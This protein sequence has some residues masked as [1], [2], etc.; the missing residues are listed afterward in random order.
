M[1]ELSHNLWF[2][3]PW[4]NPIFAF[5]INC[6]T[7]VASA[8]TFKRYHLEHHSFQGTDVWDADIPTKLEGKL[9]RYTPTKILWDALQPFFYGFRPIIMKPKPITPLEI[10]NWIVVGTFDFLV[11]HYWGHKALIYLF[12]G[13]V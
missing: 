12:L 8:A 6:P 2:A 10:Y 4:L 9:F 7:C 5:F 11:L 13:S 3:T 1:H